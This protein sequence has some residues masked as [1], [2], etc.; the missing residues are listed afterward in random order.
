LQKDKVA[1]HGYSIEK[2]G[3]LLKY[4]VIRHPFETDHDQEWR[5]SRNMKNSQDEKEQ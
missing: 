1:K 4:K 5:P 2:T 3:S